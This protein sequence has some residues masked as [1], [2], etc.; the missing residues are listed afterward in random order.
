MRRIVRMTGAVCGAVLA[1]GL[2]GSPASAQTTHTVLLES[3]SFAPDSLTI[4]EGDTV[5]WV[6]NLGFHN[7]ESG[8]AG[9]HDGIF[10]SG[11]PVS[12]PN[13]F[14]VTFDAAFLSMNP[15]PGNVYNYY[16]MVH[17][18]FGQEGTITVISGP[19]PV[20]ALP[21]WGL[22]SVALGVVGCGW[23]LLRKKRGGISQA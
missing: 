5:N 7:V 15:Q 23:V 22:L 4:A 16:C 14:A 6:W 10:R 13:S 20:P 11:D 8:S 9:I 18:A 19:V 2:L 3:I 17:Q 21:F 12:P 1:L